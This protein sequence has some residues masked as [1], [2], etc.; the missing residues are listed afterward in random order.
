M[1]FDEWFAD[2]EGDLPTVTDATRARMRVAFL[3]GID[4]GRR[5]RKPLVETCKALRDE[6]AGVCLT[7]EDPKARI[8]ATLKAVTDV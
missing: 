3:A 8:I 5:E 7:K 1:A 4:E 6:Y 2:W